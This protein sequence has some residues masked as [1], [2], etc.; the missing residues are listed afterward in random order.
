[1]L[2]GT[3][4]TNK[5]E[6]RELLLRRMKE[7]ALRT[8]AVFGGTAE[9]EALPGVP[10]LICDPT[11]TNDMV[12]YMME[13]GVPNAKPYPGITASA[14]EDF[15]VIAEKVPSAFM[16]LSAGY[17]DERG[18]ATAHNPKV[19]FNEDVCPIGV[20]GYVHCAVEWLKRH[21]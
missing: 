11:V 2:A 3:I 10:P 5:P 1:M 6:A 14:S 20:A 21:R 16:Y 13:V 4:R 18:E 9:I 15:A 12:K 17:E 19:Q 8:A 7:V